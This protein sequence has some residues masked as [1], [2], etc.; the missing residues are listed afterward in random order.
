FAPVITQVDLDGNWLT[1]MAASFGNGQ[2][3]AFLDQFT[4]DD[5]FLSTPVYA[6]SQ[7]VDFT[8]ALDKLTLVATE[9]GTALGPAAGGSTDAGK[10]IEIHAAHSTLSNGTR[11]AS[12]TDAQGNLVARAGHSGREVT[13]DDAVLGCIG[14]VAADSGGLLFAGDQAIYLR[15]G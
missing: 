5:P 2:Y 1:T 4:P 7:S 12:A 8:V 15:T 6:S 10:C 13:P 11:P 14:V 9:N 3:S